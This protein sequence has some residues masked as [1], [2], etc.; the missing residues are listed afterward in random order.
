MT[1]WET[2][3]HQCVPLIGV[4][5][6]CE[7]AGGNLLFVAGRQHEVFAPFAFIKAGRS[8]VLD[9]R[10][11]AIVDRAGDRAFVGGWDFE[12]HGPGILGIEEGDE[13]DRVRIR[14]ESLV[15]PVEK[16][17]PV[18][19]LV[20]AFTG[21]GVPDHGL[22]HEVEIHRWSSPDDGLSRAPLDAA[23]SE[24][25]ERKS[26]RGRRCYWENSCFAHGIHI[27]FVFRMVTKRFRLKG[28]RFIDF[29]RI[30]TRVYW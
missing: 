23:A 4:S 7:I 26:L 24:V 22:V 6:Q 13:I 28:A 19:D 5:L 9:G 10:L 17:R 1:S 16:T 27:S 18:D 20:A 2:G 11:P 12:H 14:S 15:F 8:D 21:F 25:L 3:T 29:R 30:E